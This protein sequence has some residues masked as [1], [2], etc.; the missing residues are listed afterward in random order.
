ME[1]FNPL[2]FLKG[3]NLKIMKKVIYSA[4]ALT[5]SMTLFAFTPVKENNSL[6]N[7]VRTDVEMLGGRCQTKMENDASFTKC[8]ETWTETIEAELAMQSNVLDN[9]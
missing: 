1:L 7:I 6:D 8:D 9:Y 2:F 5:L 4:L 3:I